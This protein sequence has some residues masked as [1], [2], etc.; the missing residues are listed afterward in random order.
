MGVNTN[1]TN[2]YLWICSEINDVNNRKIINYIH[3]VHTKLGQQYKTSFADS[4]LDFIYYSHWQKSQGIIKFSTA[5]YPLSSSI[6]LT[7]IRDIINLFYWTD[8][9][10]KALS[11]D[12]IWSIPCERQEKEAKKKIL[13][14]ILKI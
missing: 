14:N 5:S 9:P 13:S 3:C 7:T 2:S 11:R 1:I 6:I 8:Q 10:W 4:L 12:E